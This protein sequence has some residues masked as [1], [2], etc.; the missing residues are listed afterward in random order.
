MVNE[1]MPEKVG[2]KLRSNLKA[3]K[4]KHYAM[5]QQNGVCVCGRL[6]GAC[7]CNTT[8]GRK[9]PKKDREEFKPGP[10]RFLHGDAGDSLLSSMT[11]WIFN[12]RV[13]LKTH[14]RTRNSGK[15][16]TTGGVEVC[17]WAK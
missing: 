12:L 9:A 6:C 17:L 1:N 16:K 3:Y 15:E 14:K 10:F 4:H 7:V 11:S 8:N 5:H 13:H 2:G